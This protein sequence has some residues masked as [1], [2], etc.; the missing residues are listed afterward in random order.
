MPSTL[1]LGDET[2][3][4]PK[5]G[6]AESGEGILSISSENSDLNRK[7][8]FVQIKTFS[9]MRNCSNFFKLLCVIS[10]TKPTVI[11]RETDQS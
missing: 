11:K 5:S 6:H 10:S 2:R 1:G 9:L 7:L 8:V 3:E 4:S